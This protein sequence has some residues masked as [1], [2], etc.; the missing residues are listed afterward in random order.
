[1]TAV[2]S[3]TVASTVPSAVLV[4]RLPPVPTSPAYILSCPNCGGAVSL[5]VLG[6]QS[7]PW[8]CW[9]CSRGWWPSELT[10]EARVAW[11]GSHK[12]YGHGPAGRLVRAAVDGDVATAVKYG[13]SVPPDRLGLLDAATLKRLSGDTRVDATFRGWVDA[14]ILSRATAANGTSA[15]PAGTSAVGPQ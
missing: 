10:A 9:R 2:A 1:M 8:G 12:D 6:A 15:A 11:R 13:T 5:V 3:A 4:R 7:A 14:E